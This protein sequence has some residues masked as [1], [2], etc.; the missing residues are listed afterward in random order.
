MKKV[1][2]AR[3]PLVSMHAPNSSPP[4]P[5]TCS[6]KVVPSQ[7]PNL[8]IFSN[9][10]GS[11]AQSRGSAI[12]K[13]NE[14][15]LEED[16]AEDVDADT[17]RRLDATEASLAA[18]IDGSV[19]DV[20]TRDDGIV[21]ADVE[22]YGWECGIA[23]VGVPALL[24]VVTSTTDGA[25][26]AAHDVVWEVE[27]GG[28]RVGDPSD[29]GAVDGGIKAPETLAAVHIDISHLACM[30]IG[31][32]K[33]EVEGTRCAL[34]EVDGEERTGEGGDNI[35]EESLLL[36]RLDGVESVKGETEKSVVLRVLLELGADL[37][38]QL[39]GLACKGCSPNGNIIRVYVSG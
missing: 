22:S 26:V 31:I 10:L 36:D 38:S 12:L 6:H 17:R 39:D 29:G 27:E 15:T 7:I 25:V 13:D 23:R 18:L 19:V 16:V 21:A 8:K 20:A 9:L 33:A 5:T 11:K 37:L 32:H 3:S 1:N 14:L 35:G 34:L 24:L 4:S 28:S 30:L 2:N